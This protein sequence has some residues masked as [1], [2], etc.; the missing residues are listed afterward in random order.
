MVAYINLKRIE[1]G[2]FRFQDLS[3]SLLSASSAW[4]VLCIERARNRASL[5]PRHSSF[6]C[7]K[8]SPH[9]VL[10]IWL[11]LTACCSL[12]SEPTLMFSGEY[13]PCGEVHAEVGAGATLSCKVAQTEITWFREGRSLDAYVEARVCTWSLVVRQVGKAE[14]EESGWKVRTW[15]V[16][17][18]LTVTGGFLEVLLNVPQVKLLG[19]EECVM[20][21]PRSPF[22]HKTYDTAADRY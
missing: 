1:L 21:P 3:C 19:S 6:E 7:Q 12:S 8:A 5:G 11:S 2:A 9:P 14:P 18:Q 15:K 13:L 22:P 16:S 17:F 20:M 4:E 10:E